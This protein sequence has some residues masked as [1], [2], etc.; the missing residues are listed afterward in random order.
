[1][2]GIAGFF[3][4]VDLSNYENLIS[5]MNT[6]LINTMSDALIFFFTKMKKPLAHKQFSILY[7][8]IYPFRFLLVIL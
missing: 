3:S 2:C 1:M 4:N 6:S 8:F 5:K 7:I